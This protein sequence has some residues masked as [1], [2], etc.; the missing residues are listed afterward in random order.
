MGFVP[1]R[2]IKLIDILMNIVCIR[3]F[4]RMYISLRATLPVARAALLLTAAVL[5]FVTER[6][7]LGEQHIV[8]RFILRV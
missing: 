7:Q 4:I 2:R 8:R 3:M 6:P 1:L 5:F